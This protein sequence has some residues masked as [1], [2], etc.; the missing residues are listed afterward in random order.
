MRASI[1]GV[2]TFFMI[3]SILQ[4]T[5]GILAIVC[6]FSLCLKAQDSLFNIIPSHDS[7]LLSDDSHFIYNSFKVSYTGIEKKDVLVRIRPVNGW[8]IVSDSVRKLSLKMDSSLI[9]PITLART[10][11]STSVWTEVLVE[12]LSFPDSSITFS[13]FLIRANP[14]YSFTIRSASTELLLEETQTSI[15]FPFILR[16]EG[17]SR[18][19]YRINFRSVEYGINKKFKCVL[20]PGRDTVFKKEVDW[21]EKLVIGKIGL[22]VEVSDTTG[23]SKIILCNLFKE[24]SSIKIHKSKHEF[25][26]ITFETGYYKLGDQL[27]YYWGISGGLKFKQSDLDFKYR[28]KTLGIVNTIEKNIFIGNWSSKKL[29]VSIGQLSDFTSFYSYGPGISFQFKPKER[30]RIGLKFIGKNDKLVYTGNMISTFFQYSIKKTSWKHGITF[31]QDYYRQLSSWVQKNDIE[32]R[33]F[34]KNKFAFNVGIGFEK[35]LGVWLRAYT[36]GL[37]FGYKYYRQVNQLVFQSEFQRNNNSF[38]GIEKGLFT[39]MHSI[40]WQKKKYTFGGFFQYNKT[41]STFFRDTIFQADISMFNNRKF[42]LRLSGFNSHNNLG[43]AFGWY[44]QIGQTGF[45]VPR[46]LFSDLAYS[47]F[48][49]SGFRIQFSSMNGLSGRYKKNEILHFTSTSL[50]LGFKK[51]GAKTFYIQNPIFLDREGKVWSGYTK[52]ML[53]GGYFN[54][55]FWKYFSANFS[56]TISRSLYDQRKASNVSI[57]FRYNNSKRNLVMEWSGNIPI[58]KSNAPGILGSSF[59]TYTFSLRKTFNFPNIFKR[60]YHNLKVTAFND[61]NNNNSKDEGEITLSNIDLMIGNLPMKTDSMGELH[62][63]NTDTGFY[64]IRMLSANPVV[65]LTPLF[66]RDFGIDLKKDTL[67]LLPFRKSCVIKGRVILNKDPLSSIKLTL[68]NIRVMAIDSF[69]HGYVA[70]TNGNGEYSIELPASTYIVS[71]NPLAFG[72][73]VKPE[74]FQYVTN[75]SQES[76]ATVNF[77]L[78]EKRRAVRMLKK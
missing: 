11:Y 33:N 54:F 71:L 43:I 28:T 46:Y 7:I 75:V 31:N 52:T 34:D 64:R 3:R 61:L 18:Q 5:I 66:Q 30:L 14:I 27:S 29:N 62:Y 10:K 76:I 1:T 26:P 56:G 53:L 44:K 65:G 40:N 41:V 73:A 63:L 23:Q 57:N 70:L 55:R 72:D 74:Q 25:V 20:E 32:L 35:R 78:I 8:R 45:L 49:K 59:P 42:G 16:N 22:Q 69:G 9:Y 6:S 36:P 38:P 19:E 37:S 4:F 60:T 17:N 50:T 47:Y 15:L 12:L 51:F 13:K 48:A 39:Q 68:E 21:P 2:L 67:L 77:T 24:K 58:V